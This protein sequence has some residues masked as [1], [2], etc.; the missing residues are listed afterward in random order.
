[1]QQS[2]RFF[3]DSDIRRGF[4]RLPLGTFGPMA[5]KIAANISTGMGK[6]SN[7]I[8]NSQLPLLPETWTYSTA[9]NTSIR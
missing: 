2:I 3:S 9:V 5:N 4:L 1:M 8:N 6:I 7:A